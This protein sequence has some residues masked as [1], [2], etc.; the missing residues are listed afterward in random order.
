MEVLEQAAAGSSFASSHT[1]QP[2]RRVDRYRFARSRRKKSSYTLPAYRKKRQATLQHQRQLVIGCN[3]AGDGSLRTHCKLD[4][5]LD[6]GKQFGC[7]LWTRFRP[8]GDWPRL[9]PMHREPATIVLLHTSYDVDATLVFPLASF[10]CCLSYH[11]NTP[12]ER[13]CI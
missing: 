7:Y 12:L 1:S 9:H 13:H 2:A 8:V 3:A 11:Y 6:K 10:H 4:G 5:R